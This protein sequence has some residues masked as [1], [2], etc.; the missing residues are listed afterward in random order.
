MESLDNQKGKIYQTGN[1]HMSM[2]C[3][4]DWSHRTQELVNT[5][6]MT[7]NTSLCA[8]WIYT[9]YTFILHKLSIEPVNV[10]RTAITKNARCIIFFHQQSPTHQIA[11]DLVHSQRV[12]LLWLNYGAQSKGT[13]RPW[14]MRS[15]K[16]WECCKT[17]K[18]VNQA[19][20]LVS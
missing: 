6:H 10:I 14:Q 18:R 7:W 1:I 13:L 3:L 5:L 4:Q 19:W 17:C 9:K 20:Y 16:C 12:F 15:E 8:C 11:T 2:E